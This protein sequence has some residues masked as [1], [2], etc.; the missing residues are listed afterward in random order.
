MSCFWDALLSKLGAAAKAKI[1][2]PH[3]PKSMLLVLQKLNI[4]TN[5]HV[6]WQGMR[7]SVM[8]SAEHMH[9]V[10]KFEEVSLYDGHLTGACDSFLLLVCVLCNVSIIYTSPHGRFSY[11]RESPDSIV[12]L[13][14]SSSHMS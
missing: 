8:E 2:N 1:G 11:T 10:A 12:Q 5:A 13:R 4:N 14:S 3:D 9:A 6:K 7:L